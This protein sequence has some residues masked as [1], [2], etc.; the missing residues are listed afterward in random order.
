V[1]YPNTTQAV[2]ISKHYGV[3]GN[4]IDQSPPMQAVTGVDNTWSFQACKTDQTLT[5]NEELL[6]QVYNSENA[7]IASISVHA[8]LQSVAAAASGYRPKITAISIVGNQVLGQ[9]SFF[10][11]MR[12]SIDSLFLRAQLTYD[13]GTTQT[14][15]IDNT[16][17]FLY[18]TEDFVASY[19][20][21]VQ[22]L[23]VKYYLSPGELTDQVD[24]L[25]GFIS[26]EVTVTVLP[27]PSQLAGKISVIP[28]W[29]TGSSSYKL[30][31]F[32]YT[33]DRK[34][35][36]DITNFV[37]ISSGT[38]VGTTYGQAQI[39]TLRVDL[40]QVDPVSYTTSTIYTQGVV[41]ILQPVAALVRYLLRDSLS[42]TYV[43]GQDSSVSRRPVLYYDATLN[44]YFVPA[45]VFGSL[46][47][48]LLSFYTNAN[49][50]F[51]INQ[52]T[53]APQPTHFLLRDPTSGAM[54]VPAMIPIAN[55]ASAFNVIGSA[56]SYVKG[57]VIVEF[58]QQV[59]NS[60]LI[61][62]GSPC[63]VYAGTFSS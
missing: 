22:Q 1:R 42:S 23:L 15:P 13:D 51:D 5:D 55:Y 31:Y 32:Y 39:V 9:T 54:I 30:R 2:V 11:Y 50:P 41:I 62:W 7:L 17:C 33:L 6:L 20:G 45:A 36:V 3:S 63:D 27:H 57:T 25:S 18:G 34:A 48:F 61:L 26:A 40:N 58:V 47:A 52:E 10:V 24:P 21:L 43:Y 38:F 16:Q 29:D 44:Q 49:P 53:S 46:A 60:N 35:S 59:G 12:Q 37:T 8:K 56:G 14:V 19:P 4:Y 28:L